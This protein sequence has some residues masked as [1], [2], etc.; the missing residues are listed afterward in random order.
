M[1]DLRKAATKRRCRL[2]FCRQSRMSSTA[3]RLQA[4]AKQLWRVG[5]WTATG[6]SLPHAQKQGMH[7]SLRST[8]ACNAQTHQQAG[9]DR[10]AHCCQSQPSP[11]RPVHHNVKHVGN[12]QAAH[13]LVHIVAQ[14]GAPGGQC[15]SAVSLKVAG[16]VGQLEAG[17]GELLR[18]QL[19]TE[20]RSLEWPAVTPLEQRRGPRCSQA[21]PTAP[22]QVAHPLWQ[23]EA[24][25]GERRGSRVAQRGPQNVLVK[26][27]LRKVG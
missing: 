26:G 13:R 27:A 12:A 22:R 11:V 7:A 9:S 24:Q 8:A 1:S 23:H 20:Q 21:A 6:G 10:Q 18:C 4:G 17:R 16:S 15:R 25:E 5:N 2:V 3:G 19:G 14:P